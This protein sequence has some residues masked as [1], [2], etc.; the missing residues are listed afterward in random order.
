MK[1]LN[2][3]LPFAVTDAIAKYYSL[4]IGMHEAEALIAV[5]SCIVR[6]SSSK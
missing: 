1:P 4:A 6:E 3:H 2:S 5:R